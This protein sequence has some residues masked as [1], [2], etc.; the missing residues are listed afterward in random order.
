MYRIVCFRIARRVPTAMSQLGYLVRRSYRQAE[1]RETWVWWR[2]SVTVRG[3]VYGMER[4]EKRSGIAVVSHL[5]HKH[6]GSYAVQ[7]NGTNDVDARAVVVV[8]ASPLL[9][10]RG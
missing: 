9:V 7:K 5:Q 3:K 6:L 4:S 10:N 8:D 2:P 1:V